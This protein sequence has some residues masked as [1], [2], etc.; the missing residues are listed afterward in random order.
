DQGFIKSDKFGDL[1]D[2]VTRRHSERAVV[3]VKPTDTLLRA[4]ALMRLYDVSQLPVMEGEKIVG[5][6]DEND[7]L[8]AV[9]GDGNRFKREVRDYMTSR[10]KTLDVTTSL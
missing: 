9:Y 6:I 5:I 2:L 8:Y 1:R 3:T 10:L 4:N 7:V